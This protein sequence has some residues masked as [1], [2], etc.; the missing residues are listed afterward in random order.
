MNLASWLARISDFFIVPTHAILL[1]VFC[2][3][4]HVYRFTLTTNQYQYST[5]LFTLHLN[6]PTLPVSC[7]EP[8]RDPIYD[9]DDE[10][11]FPFRNLVPTELE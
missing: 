4:N 3:L 2:F 5:T 11:S 10:P 6:H 9:V 8:F 1:Y 7:A